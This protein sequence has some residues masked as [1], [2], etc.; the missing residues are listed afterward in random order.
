MMSTGFVY[1]KR[2][3][4]YNS[5]ETTVLN[6]PDALESVTVIDMKSVTVIDIQH[7]KTSSKR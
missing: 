3:K 6:V 1:R 7:S 2:Q 4:I 5:P